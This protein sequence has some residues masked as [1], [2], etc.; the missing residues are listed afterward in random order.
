MNGNLFLLY[1]PFSYIAFVQFLKFQ[2]NIFIILFF[3]EFVKFSYKD[4]MEIYMPC[5][6]FKC[7][8]SRVIALQTS[9]QHTIGFLKKIEI[10]FSLRFEVF[11]ERS[12]SP[13]ILFGDQ[14]ESSLIGCLFKNVTYHISH[15]F[16]G[17]QTRISAPR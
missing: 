11:N 9:T 12:K 3:G 17:D 8:A 7:L 6:K 14:K 4:D 10:T 2:H 16:S 5:L 1:I 13:T 15:I